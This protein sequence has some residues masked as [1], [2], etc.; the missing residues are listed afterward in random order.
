[1]YRKLSPVDIET[2]EK[3]LKLEEIMARLEQQLAQLRADCKAGGIKLTEET[4]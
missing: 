2:I 3:V 4:P 1:M